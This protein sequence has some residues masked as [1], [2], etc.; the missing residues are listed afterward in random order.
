MSNCTPVQ[1]HRHEARTALNSAASV[2]EG[3]PGLTQQEQ[4]DRLTAAL[5]D[6]KNAVA[7]LT[8]ALKTATERDFDAYMA[9]KQKDEDED[10]NE[11]ED[12]VPF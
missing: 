6:A 5:A 1:C 8:D 2:L 3:A 11:D 9:T 7:I 4:A 10:V 12:E